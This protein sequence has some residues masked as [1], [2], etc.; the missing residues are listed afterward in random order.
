MPQVHAG[1]VLDPLDAVPARGC[2]DAARSSH[3]LKQHLEEIR[4]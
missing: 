3:A 2:R 1:L 4:A